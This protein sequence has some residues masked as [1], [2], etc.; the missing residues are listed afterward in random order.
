MKW[1]AMEVA[2]METLRSLDR[3]TRRAILRVLSGE[4]GPRVDEAVEV[5]SAHPNAKMLVTWMLRLP[6][7]IPGPAVRCRGCGAD[8]EE[9][10]GPRNKFCE[11]C[12]IQR[13]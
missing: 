3:R 4:R 2:D 6:P 5:L 10:Y 13:A 7:L 8:C 11:D 9:S 1:P 12:W